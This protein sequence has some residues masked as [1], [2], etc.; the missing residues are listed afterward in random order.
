[1]VVWIVMAVKF[2]GSFRKR[3]RRLVF[4]DTDP[5][6]RAITESSDNNLIAEEVVLTEEWTWHCSGCRTDP[7]KC[8]IGLCVRT[9]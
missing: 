4:A 8:T 9:V 5:Q 3:Y 6:A 2:V 7:S 1:M